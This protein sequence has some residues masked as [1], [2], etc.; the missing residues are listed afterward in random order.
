M[1]N[2][3]KIYQKNLESCGKPY[4][5]ILNFFYTFNSSPLQVLDLGCGQGRDAI[6]IAKLGH[7]VLGVDISK[8]GISQMMTVAK[9]EH[10]AING[11]IASA[12]EFKWHKKFD[13]VLM[14]RLI[15]MFKT[16]AEKLSLMNN[17]CGLTKRNGYVLIADTPKN[18]QMILK[19]FKSSI[20]NSV[21]NKNGFTFVN[22]RD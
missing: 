15:H 16:D 11:I 19:I 5:E 6:P 20:W 10:L 7:H 4:P 12:L 3:N 8:T 13:I 14:D 22:K 18:K 9:K 21:F 17:A 2:Y 1:T